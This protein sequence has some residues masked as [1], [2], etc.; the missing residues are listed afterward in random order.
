MSFRRIVVTLATT[1]LALGLVGA[2]PASAHPARPAHSGGSA[3]VIS[4]AIP[5]DAVFP[6]G[7]ATDPGSHFFYVGS[8][9]DGTIYRGLVGQ[10][11]AVRV[12]LPGG[13]D[14]RTAATGLKVR[15]GR[16]YVAGAGTGLIFVYDLSSRRL[17]R[18]F[19]TGHRDGF[20][21]DIAFDRAGNAYVTDSMVPVLWRVPARA[22]RRGL[23]TGTPEAF[24]NFTGTPAEFGPGLNVNG[25]V[26]VGNG[27]TLLSVATNSGGLFA[28][29][30][31]SRRVTEVPVDGGPLTAGDGMLLADGRLLVMRNQFGLA[32]SVKLRGASAGDSTAITGTVTGA[33]TSPALAF[34]TTMAEAHGRLLVVNSQFD[35]QGG[36]PVLPF[37]VADFP[38]STVIS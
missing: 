7:V 18:S 11:G 32:V 20:L 2:A 8:S 31:R 28:I 14:G 9:T 34:P 22:V 37:T 15:D 4:H 19:D 35:K 3:D 36:T 23:P 29:D 17:I 25:I 24:V 33:F 6:E 38:A 12:F 30:T 10:P 26:S 16:L 5:G 21:N 27:R 13:A 1:G